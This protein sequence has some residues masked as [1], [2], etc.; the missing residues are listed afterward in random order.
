[1]IFIYRERITP[2]NEIKGCEPAI[3]Q[4]GEFVLDK[5]L[6]LPGVERRKHGLVQTTF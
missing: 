6:R 4:L 3:E 2:A 5:Y 1:V